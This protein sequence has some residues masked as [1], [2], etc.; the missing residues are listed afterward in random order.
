MQTVLRL[1]LDDRE[2]AYPVRHAIEIVP[3]PEELT[4]A[5]D[6]VAAGIAV[7]EGR[8][9]EL[10]DPLL[11]LDAVGADDAGDR[12]V[13]LLHGGEG[14]WMEAF[15]RPSIEAAGYR[16]VRQLAAGERAGVALTMADEGAGEAP[17]GRVIRLAKT[18]GEGVYRYDRAA[19]VAALQE[20]KA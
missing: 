10:L 18:R 7:I 8:P 4:P 1:Q 2:L 15:L 20:A 16:V 12:P 17:A 13:C 14:P 9:V 19:L 6:G 11:L 3:L 5:S